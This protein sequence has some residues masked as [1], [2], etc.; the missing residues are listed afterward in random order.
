MT[1]MM[2]LSIDDVRSYLSLQLERINNKRLKLGNVSADNGAISAEIV[3]IDNS[4]VQR[5]KVDHHTGA[6]EYEN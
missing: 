3:T 4:L 6:L 1:P 2:N 5:L